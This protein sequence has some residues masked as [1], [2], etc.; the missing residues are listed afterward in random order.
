MAALC[1]RLYHR[2]LQVAGSAGLSCCRWGLYCI[3]LYCIVLYCIVRCYSIIHSIQTLYIYI[4]ICDCALSCAKCQAQLKHELHGHRHEFC[5]AA[6]ASPSS[7]ATS[8]FQ[9]STA[10]MSLQQVFAPSD[11]FFKVLA[12]RCCCLEL[13]FRIRS[14]KHMRLICVGATRVLREKNGTLEI[15][16]LAT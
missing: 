5:T 7:D 12:D 16:N 8:A 4:Y 13:R 9:F 3:V 6:A 1:W 14:Q 10:A 15:P 11:L 2:T